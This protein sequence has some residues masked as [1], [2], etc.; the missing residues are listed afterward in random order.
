MDDQDDQPRVR[1]PAKP[2]RPPA[3]S[4]LPPVQTY[5][6]HDGNPRR[7]RAPYVIP[8]SLD[9]HEIL[10]FETPLPEEGRRSGWAAYLTDEIG[11][12]QGAVLLRV[13]PCDQEPG[14]PFAIRELRLIADRPT[15]MPGS[16]LLRLIPW[17]RIESAVNQP[18]RRRAL[19]E[20]VSPFHHRP[21][22]PKYPGVWSA[23]RPREPHPAP[24]LHLDVPEGYRKP[25]SFYADV[26]ERFL[27]AGALN[28]RPAQDLAEANG[29]K[30]T[31]VHRWIREA[32]ARGLLALPTDRRQ[33]EHGDL[34]AECSR[35]VAEWEWHQRRIHLVEVTST[36]ELNQYRRDTDNPEAV[37]ARLVRKSRQAL[38]E[39]EPNLVDVRDR[40]RDLGLPLPDDFPDLDAEALARLA[41]ASEPLGAAD[42]PSAHGIDPT[43][44]DTE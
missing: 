33:E 1:L 42:A 10:S 27:Q 29:V 22:D 40:F 28:T 19:T 44:E 14:A 39:I 13:S 17:E 26:A 9:D 18:S 24:D 12:G 15:S 4:D 8:L 16:S 37:D 32:K 21:S 30:P 5:T 38:E 23:H 41:E 2:A 43:T 6:G 11:F 25:D 36:P 31:T 7:F 20:L 3:R 34:Y 35:L